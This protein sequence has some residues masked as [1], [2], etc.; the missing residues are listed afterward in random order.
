MSG[1][2]TIES[3]PGVFTE[4]IEKFG[5][6]G[7]QVEELWTLDINELNNVKPVYGL[8][9]LF[10]WNT[11]ID[12][13][14]SLE[15]IPENLFFSNQIVTNACATQAI[16][17]ILLNIDTN[18]QKVD[19][20]QELINFKTFNQGLP[21]DVIGESIGSFD[22]I[23]EAHNSFARPEPFIIEEERKPKKDE[24]VFHFIAY[25]PVHN[26]LYELDGL[27]PGPILLGDCTDE[28]WLEKI[29][30]EIQDRINRYSQNEIKFNLLA[31]IRNRKDVFNEQIEELEKKEQ[32]N[33]VKELINELKEKIRYEDEKRLQWRTENARRRHNY[34][35][36]LTNLLRVLAEEGELNNLIEK[37]KQK[38]QEQ[39][40]RAG[41]KKD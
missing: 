36:F 21:P 39:Q 10:K 30:P 5:V 38:M 28:N 8:I 1:W 7:V 37:G 9:F 33:E 11:E 17:S 27:K 6:K 15:Q 13:R 25:V 41:N 19:L 22:L 12:E 26:T 4:L 29:I 18:K 32:T 14:A 20:G 23:K 31:V 24:D 35:P 40:Q 34:I 2:T 16:L 3:D